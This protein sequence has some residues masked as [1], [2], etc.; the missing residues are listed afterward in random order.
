MKLEKLGPVGPNSNPS[1]SYHLVKAF[2]E[3]PALPVS[4]ELRRLQALG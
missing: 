2:W 1:Q 4:N 3:G